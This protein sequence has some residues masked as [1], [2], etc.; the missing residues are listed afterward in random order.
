MSGKKRMEEELASLGKMR[1]LGK[2]ASKSLLEI[3]GRL[4][5][6]KKN[7]EKV[8][9]GTLQST[10]DVS[11]LD[12]M[13][14]YGKNHLEETT[15]NLSDATDRIQNIVKKAVSMGSEATAQHEELTTAVSETEEEADQVI[16]RIKS[17]RQT[18]DD[19][20]K[21]S[22]QAIHQSDQMKKNMG[23]LMEIIG[24]MNDVTAEITSISSQTNL[25]AL[26]ASIEAAR[27]GEAGRGFAVVAEEIR[28]LAD[29]TK[30]LTDSMGSFLASIHSAS[31]KSLSSVDITVSDLESMNRGLK[32]IGAQNRENEEHVGR[33]VE[34]LHTF[35]A[36]S[37]EVCNAIINLET[38]IGLISEESDGIYRQSVEL[39]DIDNSL[40]DILE[41][42]K[43]IENGLDQTVKLLGIMSQ[44]TF[45]MIENKI[46]AD[47]IKGGAKAHER[48]LDSLKL[49][50]EE[51]KIKP[52][53]TNEKKCGF[54]HFYYSII[55]KNREIVD[56]WNKLE[57]KHR[58][59]HQCAISVIEQIKSDG[60]TREMMEKAQRLSD[61]LQKDFADILHITQELDKK[62]LNVFEE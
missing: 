11:S 32:V 58:N 61:E 60:D 16:E 44:D 20:L 38:Q 17:G 15:K 1:P 2:S 41:P 43:R 24:R 57:E 46:F 29:E 34:Y 39:N 51:Q 27:A 33:I 55:P 4:A 30:N 49:M 40:S 18:L 54:G 62:G 59:F 8:V 3:Q 35:A 37:H 14:T 6:G 25:L 42:I 56:I 23:D 10:M 26:N 45:Y 50:A 21:V 52:L 36:L 31:K 48:W 12:L 7:F 53:Q 28:N 13:L 9:T 19:M 5:E 22:N 47:C